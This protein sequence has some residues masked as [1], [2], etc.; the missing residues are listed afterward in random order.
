MNVRDLDLTSEV[1]VLA[2]FLRDAGGP[3]FTR[4]THDF[5][6][7]LG[8]SHRNAVL[9]G[10]DGTIAAFARS[11]IDPMRGIGE[12]VWLPPAAHA[13]PWTKSLLTHVMADAP[14]SLSWTLR[15]IGHLMLL[16]GGLI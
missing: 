9:A 10:A 4:R 6:R 8:A 1:P 5:G 3:D 12:L 14:E 2:R 15:D 16:G 7:L 11:T 13:A